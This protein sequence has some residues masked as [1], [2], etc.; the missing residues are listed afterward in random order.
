METLRQVREKK[1]ETQME[2]TKGFAW[3]RHMAQG[4]E[5]SESTKEKEVEKERGGNGERERER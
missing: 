3:V 1:I 2:I 5:P 4:T